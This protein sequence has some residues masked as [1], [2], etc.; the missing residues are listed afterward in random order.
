MHLV[1]LPL[2]FNSIISYVDVTDDNTNHSTD[3]VY[4]M[5]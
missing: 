2:I 4:F 1:N 3:S 5:N